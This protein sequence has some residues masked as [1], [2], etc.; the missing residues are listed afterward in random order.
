MK[1]NV[2]KRHPLVTT[3]SVVSA[4]FEGFFKKQ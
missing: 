2:E 3:N 4:N 1:A